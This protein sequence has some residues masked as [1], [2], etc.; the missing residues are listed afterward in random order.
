M[1]AEEVTTIDRRRILNT[2]DQALF[3]F[4]QVDIRN[5]LRFTSFLFLWF[6]AA[7]VVIIEILFSQQSPLANNPIIHFYSSPFQVEEEEVMVK[8]QF[9]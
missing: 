3:L 4:L 8:R 1:A 7:V 5:R 9:D 6:T 2:L